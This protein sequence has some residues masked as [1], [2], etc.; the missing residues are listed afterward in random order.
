[1][2]TDTLTIPHPTSNGVA[3]A[4]D[5]LPAVD[6]SQPD[7]PSQRAE[8]K[9]PW[10]LKLKDLPALEGCG[11]FGATLLVGAV[12][13]LSVAATVTAALYVAPLEP[14]SP[15]VPNWWVRWEHVVAPVAGAGMAL[16][17]AAAIAVIRR[18][19]TFADRLD[20][21]GYGQLQ[22][23]LQALH[24]RLLVLCGP[25]GSVCQDNACRAACLEAGAHADAI[26]TALETPGARWVLGSGF[27]DAWRHLHAAEQ[28][29]FLALPP[30][31]VA[32]EGL[33]DE[34]RL[35]GSTIKHRDDFTAKLRRAV[36]ILG[37]PDYLTATPNV[38]A[39]GEPLPN[40]TPEQAKTQARVI[41]R[42]VRRVINGFR[43]DKWDGLVRARG[44]LI[45]TGTLTGV[46]AYSL[47]ALAILVQAPEPAIVAAVA[48]YLVGA[49]VGLFNQLRRDSRDRGGEEDLG[50][51]RARLFYTPVLSGMAGM[52]GVVVVAL[53]YAA[54][55]EGIDIVYGE[56]G[57][58]TTDGS[59]PLLDQVFDLARNS[60]GLLLAA[61]FGLTP[62]LLVDRL[63]RTADKYRLDLLSTTPETTAV[64][65]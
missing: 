6:D 36:T 35:K 59:T 12:V 63:Q 3:G 34:M 24:V 21:H 62:D 23:R 29:L 39:L 49:T 37:A 45:W 20:P 17:A 50:F 8:G 43:D 9:G 15:V 26:I 25:D 5:L 44:R 40:Q 65:G 42:D 48:F 56:A 14:A 57:S 19:R 1:M 4:A 11:G 55:S 10:I 16:L 18:T 30:E 47:L 33:F 61:V 54:G 31:E 46:A 64:S 52:G 7:P 38:L 51:A 27:T 60:F 41:L 2:G 28:A 13:F 58:V 53:L 22:D 32:G